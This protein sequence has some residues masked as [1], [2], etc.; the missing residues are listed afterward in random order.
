MSRD[1]SIANALGVVGDRWSLLVVREL[2]YGVHRF[3]QIAE[4]TGAPTDVLTARLR[5]LTGT[6]VI[7]TRPYSDRPPRV[8]YHLTASGLDLA[9]ALLL[10]LSWGDRWVSDAPPVH[11]THEEAG[12]AHPLR[13]VVVCAGCG[14]PVDEGRISVRDPAGQDLG[15]LA[16]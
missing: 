2:L 15:R 3:A 9:P 16:G 7:E 6:G 5:K 10:L 1:C 11:L 8:E 12:E 4:R 14:Q 13:P